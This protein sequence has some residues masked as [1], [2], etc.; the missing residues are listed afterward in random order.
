MIYGALGMY[1]GLPR[2]HGPPRLGLIYPTYAA[3]DA[4]CRLGVA[5][6]SPDPPKISTC[7]G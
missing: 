6:T 4:R 5:D 7:E 3:A 2:L 1:V